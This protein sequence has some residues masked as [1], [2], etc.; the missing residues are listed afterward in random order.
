M[1]QKLDPIADLSPEAATL[2]RADLDHLIAGADVR[3]K[4][5]AELIAPLNFDEREAAMSPEPLQAL[6]QTIAGTW[7]DGSL[8]LVKRTSVTGTSH[9]PISVYRLAKDK[10]SLLVLFAPGPDASTALFG[11]MPDRAYD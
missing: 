11:V 2:L 8:A 1:P 5:A 9:R 10:E 7:P 3:P 6:Q 4:P